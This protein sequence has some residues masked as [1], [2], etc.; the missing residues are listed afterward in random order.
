MVSPPRGPDHDGGDL[1]DPNDTFKSL[2]L[3]GK[4]SM[5]GSVG[6]PVEEGLVHSVAVDAAGDE[7]NTIYDK[8]LSLSSGAGLLFN[9]TTRRMSH[10][11]MQSV[12]GAYGTGPYKRVDKHKHIYHAYPITRARQSTDLYRG[13]CRGERPE[14][15][16]TGRTASD[17]RKDRSYY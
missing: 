7:N 6:V 5:R 14:Q 12:R 15:E 11:V 13:I 9:Q 17:P 1:L 3:R 2:I 8:T 16:V 10:A 4:V